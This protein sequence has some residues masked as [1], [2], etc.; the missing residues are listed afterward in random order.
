MPSTSILPEN[1]TA[2]LRVVASRSATGEPLG[3]EVVESVKLLHSVDPRDLVQAEREIVGA[4]ALYRCHGEPSRMEKLFTGRVSDADRLRSTE[5]LEFLFLFHRDGRMREAALRKITGPLPSAFLFSAVAW[6]LNDWA[7]PVR[8]AAVECAARTFPAT[9]ARV[10]A[11]AACVLLTRQATWGRWGG[12]REI[13][14]AAFE[15]RDVASCLAD[16]MGASATGPMASLLRQALRTDG[17]DAHLRRLAVDAV[18]PAV[19]AAAIQTLIKGRAEWPVGWRWRWIDR[20]M[21][22]RRRET[23]FETRPLAVRADMESMIML[24]LDDRAG[25]V[26]SVAMS[27]LIQEQSAVADARALASAMLDDRS[28]AVRERAE[29]VIK[30]AEETSS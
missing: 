11:Q 14:N 15:R 18:Q 1:I 22:V 9:S 8:K 21:G 5:R 2:S 3:A 10:V 4:A 19:R 26:R 28:P 16:I 13:L 29:F 25:T 6:R 20:S 27:G 17:M 23:A 30:R 24:G 12:E 7:E